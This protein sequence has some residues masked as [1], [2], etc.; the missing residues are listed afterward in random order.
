MLG[1]F[2]TKIAAAYLGISKST[3]EKMRVNGGGPPFLKLG[4]SV[5]YR[6]DDLDRWL[7]ERVR[8]NTSGAVDDSGRSVP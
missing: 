4:R 2:P 1:P 3:L 6:A 7:S 5:R 8:L